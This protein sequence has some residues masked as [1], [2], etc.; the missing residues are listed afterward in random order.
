MSQLSEELEVQPFEILEVQTREY[1]IF[2]TA[3]RSGRYDLIHLPKQNY[4]I[5]LLT[6]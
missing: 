3:V 2:N 4:P 1:G 6:L 5:L